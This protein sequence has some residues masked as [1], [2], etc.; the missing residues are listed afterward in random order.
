ML[1]VLT[2]MRATDIKYFK[3]EL[4]ELLDVKA[5]KEM[6][7]FDEFV[8]LVGI[9]KDKGDAHKDCAEHQHDHFKSNPGKKTKED[10]KFVMRLLISRGVRVAG[11]R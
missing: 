1:D 9:N 4:Y 7:D 5:Q 10:T 2:S 11:M 3:E 6:V 8:Q